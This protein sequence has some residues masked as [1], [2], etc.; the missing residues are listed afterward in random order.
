MPPLKIDGVRIAGKQEDRLRLYEWMLKKQVE[1][2]KKLY[3]FDDD[4]NCNW[5]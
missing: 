1:D 3:K 2:F 5:I 4:Q